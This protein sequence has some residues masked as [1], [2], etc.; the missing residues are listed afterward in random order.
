[1]ISLAGESGEKRRRAWRGESFDSGKA[2]LGQAKSLGEV[3]RQGQ[4][5]DKPV[6]KTSDAGKRGED[7]TVKAYWGRGGG[8][9]RVSQKRRPPV[10]Q[11]GFGNTKAYLPGPS[12]GPDLARFPR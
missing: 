3:G 1:V 4:V 12:P 6:P 9:G 11:F 8:T 2:L 7:L 5:G 10:D